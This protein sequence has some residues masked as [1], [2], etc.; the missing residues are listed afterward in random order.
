VRRIYACANQ[1][2]TEQVQSAMHTYMETHPRGRFGRIIYNM[3]D[4]KLDPGALRER[5]RFYTDHFD[6][7]LESGA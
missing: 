5:F 1:P 4:F 3:A 2:F 7:E 6:V